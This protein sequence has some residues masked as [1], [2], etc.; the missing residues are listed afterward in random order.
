[1]GFTG[2]GDQQKVIDLYVGYVGRIA[3]VLASTFGFVADHAHSSLDFMPL[4][5]PTDWTSSQLLELGDASFRLVEGQCVL[6]RPAGQASQQESHSLG[7][8]DHTHERVAL[9]L[10]SGY[11]ELT[12]DGCSQAVL[13]WS[14][15]EHRWD[16][17]AFL[18]D[19]KALP[20]V[21]RSLEELMELEAVREV[22]ARKSAETALK[23][24]ETARKEGEATAQER[25]AAREA[26]EAARQAAEY[27]LKAAATA[28]FA[29]EIAGCVSQGVRAKRAG[30][31]WGRLERQEGQARR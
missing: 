6:V 9:T 11:V 22:A 3:D 5:L 15:T 10:T 13:P 4:H 25:E 19:A 21:L 16:P 20:L 27:A 26:A 7:A 28:R 18:R 17:Q 24:A 1:M 8:V 14:A 12:I 23:A 2:K 30:Q 31:E 29:V